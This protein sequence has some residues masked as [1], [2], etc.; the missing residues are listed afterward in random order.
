M[1][2]PMDE[3]QPCLQ[4]GSEL[5]ATRTFFPKTSQDELGETCKRCLRSNVEQAQVY[6]AAQRNFR[7]TSLSD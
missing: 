5:P 1:I 3:R 7:L 4:C 2:E 6:Q